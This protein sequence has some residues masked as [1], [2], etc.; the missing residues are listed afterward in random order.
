M[1][2]VKLCHPFFKAY[3][4]KHDTK[5]PTRVDVSLNKS[6]NKG[7]HIVKLEIIIMGWDCKMH[8]LIWIFIIHI[9]IMTPFSEPTDI[10][11]CLNTL[12]LVLLSPD[13]PCLCKQCRSRSVGFWRSHLIWTCTVCHSVFEFISTTWIKVIWVAENWKRTWQLHLFSRTRVNSTLLQSPQ[14]LNRSMWL[15]C[16]VSKWQTV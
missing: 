1:R 15:S 14:N 16:G 2:L 11:I 13:I 12:T 6:S 8:I 3:D 9:Y 10:H 4:I 7:W 5:W